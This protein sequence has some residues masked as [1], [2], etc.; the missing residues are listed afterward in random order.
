[1][2]SKNNFRTYL[3]TTGAI[4]AISDVFVKLLELDERPLHSVEFIRRN[5]GEPNE[6]ELEN[7]KLKIELEDILKYLKDLHLRQQ[8]GECADIDLTDIERRDKILFCCQRTKNDPNCKSML[9][10]Y[11]PEITSGKLMDIKTDTFHSDIFDCIKS[12]LVLESDELTVFAADAECYDLFNL[13]FYQII[14]DVHFELTEDFQHSTE[15]WGD[16]NVI[17][18]PDNEFFEI[19]QCQINCTRSLVGFPFFPKMNETQFVDVMNEIRTSFD[20][21]KFQGKFYDF[22]NDHE[23]IQLKSQNYMFREGDAILKASGCSK[24]WPKG[25]GI[26][27]SED[28]KFVAQINCKDHLRFGCANDGNDIKSL[29][30]QM[31]EYNKI[32][33][34][35]LQFIRHEK[36]GFLNSSPRLIGNAIEVGIL[37]SFVEPIEFDKVRDVMA[38]NALRITNYKNEGGHFIVEIRNI[39]CLGLTEVESV[40][41]CVEGLNNVNLNI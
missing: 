5:I 25:R 36:Y 21:E 32:F 26:F 19:L 38:Q 15:D 16:A 13:F 8:N 9:K 35:R 11:F 1:M 39:E 2:D 40:K 29:F 28:K 4:T 30:T 24:Y 33:Q 6:T 10:K 3:E 17:I 22:E 41:K 27:I 37:L 12:G 7:D 34:E 20:N 31:T 23:I 18:N 14:S